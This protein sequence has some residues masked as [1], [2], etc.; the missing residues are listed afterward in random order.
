MSMRFLASVVAAVAVV[1]S[2]Q[3]IGQEKKP[4]KGKR[5]DVARGNAIGE[6]V[7]GKCEFGATDTCST[8]LKLGE[9]QFVLVGGKAGE[10][11]FDDRESGRKVRVFGALTLKDGVATITGKRSAEIKRRKAKPSL[12]LRGK[13]VCS[14][15]EFKVGEGCGVGLQAGKVQVVLNGKAAESVFEIRC[16]GAQRTATGKLTKIDGDTVYLTA[17]RVVDPAKRAKAK[18]KAKAKAETGDS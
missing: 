9:K 8:A 14:K 1:V 16:S 2:V 18:K 10:D 17:M 4:E 5:A 6:L 12:T 7:C 15:C 13:L 11:L 3:A